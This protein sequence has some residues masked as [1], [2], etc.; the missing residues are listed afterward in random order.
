[1]QI[2]LERSDVKSK[3]KFKL[4]IFVYLILL[5]LVLMY[6]SGC[7]TSNYR[8]KE[9]REGPLVSEVHL[10]NST[11]FMWT[12][13]QDIFAETVD[14]D[15][16]RRTLAVGEFEQVPDANSIKAVTEGVVIGGAAVL[17]GGL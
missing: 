13:A 14:K 2:K 1:M 8:R 4:G 11:A 9:Y 3:N 10:F 5:A 7:S 12:K 6:F 16:V 17:G 15:G